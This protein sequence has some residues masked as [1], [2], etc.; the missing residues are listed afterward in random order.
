MGQGQPSPFEGC[1]AIST[2]IAAA[3]GGKIAES[4]KRELELFF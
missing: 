2:A 3:D 4:E 1:D